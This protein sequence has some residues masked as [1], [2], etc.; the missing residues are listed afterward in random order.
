ML[1]PFT[2]TI[3]KKINLPLITTIVL[4]IQEPSA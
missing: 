4:D 3:I 1:I 2:F